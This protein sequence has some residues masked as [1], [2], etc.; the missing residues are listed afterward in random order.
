MIMYLLIRDSLI[1]RTFKIQ[2]HYHYWY[3]YQWE[4]WQ[5]FSIC[6]LFYSSK[7]FFTSFFECEFHQK[8][9]ELDKIYN[10]SRPEAIEIFL[11]LLISK[12]QS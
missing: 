2:W 11:R 9:C 5:R 3:K 4:W 8:H 6:I 12:L 7:L 1:L 10:K